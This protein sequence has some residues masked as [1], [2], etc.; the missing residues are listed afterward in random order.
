V[1][2]SAVAECTALRSQQVCAMTRGVCEPTGAPCV[3]AGKDMIPHECRRQPHSR[4]CPDCCSATIT[5]AGLAVCPSQCW[6][7]TLK[8][9]AACTVC[10]HR[11]QSLCSTDALPATSSARHWQPC[12]AGHSVT[13]ACVTVQGC[14]ACV[15]RS[16]PSCLLLWWCCSTFCGQTAAGPVSSRPTYLAVPPQAPYLCSAAV[17]C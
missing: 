5:A 9:G 1:G 12:S 11:H 7:S 3:A 16:N 6:I 2:C 14:A 17:Y 15:S 4:L 10:G 8:H 13:A